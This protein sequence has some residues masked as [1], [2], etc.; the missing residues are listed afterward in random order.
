MSPEEKQRQAIPEGGCVECGIPKQRLLEIPNSVFVKNQLL[1]GLIKTGN[2]GG[3][4]QREAPTDTKELRRIGIC[5]GLMGANACSILEDPCMIVTNAHL[6]GELG[7]LSKLF[8]TQ[9]AD[10][11]DGDLIAT[12]KFLPRD[13]KGNVIRDYMDKTSQKPLI[14]QDVFQFFSE[15]NPATGEV[16]TTKGYRAEK[17]VLVNPACDLAIV[18]LAPDENGNCPGDIEDRGYFKLPPTS[19]IN[20]AMGE[21]KDTGR[22]TLYDEKPMMSCKSPKNAAIALYGFPDKE[23]REPGTLPKKLHVGLIDSYETTTNYEN[24]YLKRS[25]CYML[26]H[27]S[28]TAAGNSGSPYVFVEA[29]KNKPSHLD[30]ILGMEQGQVKGVVNEGTFWTGPF[31]ENIRR[32][33]DLNRTKLAD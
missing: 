27:K 6:F 18:K 16:E 11:K 10:R 14:K 31:V 23:A 29:G 15:R 33:I 12:G 13:P 9:S 26:S 20:Q 28:T 2:F 30:F 24:S 19:L 5:K 22:K 25:E 7:A 21:C 8:E 32:A 3:P 4:L 1:P 17:F